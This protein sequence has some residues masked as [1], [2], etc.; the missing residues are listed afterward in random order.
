MAVALQLSKG[1]SLSAEERLKRKLNR[2]R[3]EVINRRVVA[4]TRIV[5]DGISS[6]SEALGVHPKPY[7]VRPFVVRNAMRHVTSPGS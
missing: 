3:I 6:V 5:R 2:L 4:E 1:G 7:C